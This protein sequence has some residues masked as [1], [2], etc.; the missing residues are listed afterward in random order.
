[1]TCVYTHIIN[2]LLLI[3]NFALSHSLQ[4][5]EL[6]NAESHGSNTT[7]HSTRALSL[8][9]AVGLLEQARAVF[10]SQALRVR[11]PQL[12]SLPEDI[13]GELKDLLRSL[14]LSCD[15]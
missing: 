11:D 1:M 13:G 2:S 4:L 3:A 8:A 10:W 5:Q 12:D 14:H 15:L 6:E 9:D 7:L